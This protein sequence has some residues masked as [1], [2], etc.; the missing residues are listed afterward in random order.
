[1]R[2]GLPIAAILSVLVIAGAWALMRESAG[3]PR[4]ELELYCA[5]G[6]NEPV[7]EIL[8]QYQKRYGVHTHVVYDG[9]KKLFNPIIVS[10]RGDL[11]LAADASYMDEARTAGIEIHETIPIAF[12]Q[13]VIAVRNEQN[14]RKY[15]IPISDVL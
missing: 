14:R 10:G 12:Q 5:M 6:V 8:K 9:S 3:T 11:Y 2:N 4:G 1:M 15:A 7:S 13:P